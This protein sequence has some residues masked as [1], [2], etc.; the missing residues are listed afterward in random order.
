MSTLARSLGLADDARLAV[1]HVDDVGMCHGANKAYLDLFRSGGVTSGSVMVPCPWFREIAEAAAADRTLDLGVHLTLTSE[2]PH[3]RWRP[4]STASPASGLLDDDGYFPRNCLGLRQRLVPEAA[5]IEMRAQMERALAAGIE[6]THVDTHMGAAFIPELFPIYLAIG[7]DYDL[8]VLVPRDMDSYLGVL[9]IGE[10]DRAACQHAFDAA[11]AAGSPVV[12]RF[13]MTPGVESREVDMAYRRL[14]TGDGPGLTFVA[15][16]ANAPGDIETIVPPR[17]HWRTDEY[18]LFGSG[19]TR[20]W[21]AEAG[22]TTIGY[23]A[24]RDVH[25]AARS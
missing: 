22:I 1:I 24:I 8:P 14:L 9:K 19:V 11:T 23:R 2:W 6:P 16:H 18:A 5:E 20:R 10:I 3:Y 7:R 17:A 25:R 21:M 15:I 4:I 13:R 12:E